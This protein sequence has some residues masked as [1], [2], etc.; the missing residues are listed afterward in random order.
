M[1]YSNCEIWRQI[2][3]DL[4]SNTRI[5]ALCW[6]QNFSEWSNYCQGLHGASYGPVFF[7]NNY[8]IFQDNISPVHTAR[9]VQSWLEKHEDALQHLP[10]PA[11]SPDL[12]IVRPLWSAL[13]SRVRSRF[14]PSS[15]L[16]QIWVILLKELYIIP[17]ETIQNLN[18]ALKWA[19]PVACM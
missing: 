15:F 18:E 5:L 2:C 9:S 13:E 14:P 8:A 1:T 7:P 12:N 11:Q 3:D 10:L 16:K 19:I 17:I 6:S 4:S